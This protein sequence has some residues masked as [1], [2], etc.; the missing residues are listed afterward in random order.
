MTY[1]IDFT[2]KHILV[3]GGTSGIGNAIAQ[4]FRSKGGIVQVWGTRASKDN[5]AGDD[6]SDLTD[7]EYRQVDVS[8]AEQIHDACSNIEQVDV[9]VLSQGIV[10]YKREE[11]TSAGFRK[12]INTNLNSLMDCCERL[13]PKLKASQGSIIIISST[14]AFQSARGNPA[15]CASKT[16]ARGL[17]RTLGDT[18][19]RDGI[20][21]NGI[22]PGLVPTKMTAATT[23]NPEV[24]AKML[25]NIPLGRF[26]K[27]TEVAGVALFLASPLAA[28]VIGQTLPVD[29]GL[30]LR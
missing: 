20:R 14:A 8:D 18:W 19:A 27:T 6:G 4:A 9:L 23:E 30:T 21:V 12:V 11:F 17:T 26:G 7:L 10:L 5:Y 2:G 13:H 1:D 3:V 25:A 24:A 22:A 15:Y 29:G 16:G 28:Y